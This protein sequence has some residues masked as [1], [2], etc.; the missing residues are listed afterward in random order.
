[1]PHSHADRRTRLTKNPDRSMPRGLVAAYCGL[2]HR[3][4]QLRSEQRPADLSVRRRTGYLR[5]AQGHPRSYTCS[6]PAPCP[7]QNEGIS[8]APP[9]DTSTCSLWRGSVHQ[10]GFRIKRA[11]LAYRHSSRDRKSP[12]S[13]REGLIFQDAPARNRTHGYAGV[14]VLGLRTGLVRQI[15]I[16]QA[17]AP[18]PPGSVG[19]AQK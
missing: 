11:V 13:R 3:F 8:K 10:S 6:P 15:G 16:V 9:L 5:T 7:V 14:G 12:V 4:N 18:W 19:P 2:P 1:M 17:S